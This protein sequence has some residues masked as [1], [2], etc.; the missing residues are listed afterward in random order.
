MLVHVTRKRRQYELGFVVFIECI[1]RE[2]HSNS[3]MLVGDIGPDAVIL[4]ELAESK[5]LKQSMLDRKQRYCSRLAWRSCTF[6]P[7]LTWVGT[8]ESLQPYV[9]AMFIR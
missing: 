8:L 3:L 5:E 1:S 2:P 7:G 6:F 4:S 9:S